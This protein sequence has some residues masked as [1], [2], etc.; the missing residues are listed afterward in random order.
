MEVSLLSKRCWVNQIFKWKEN[1]TLPLPIII[2]KNEFQ[3]DYKY[4]CECQNNILSKSCQRGYLHDLRVGKIFLI[5]GTK[6][7]IVYS[8]VNNKMLDYI[9]SEFFYLSRHH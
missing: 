5:Q 2:H 8:C 1:E 3:V 9:K 6:R 7:S 4:A